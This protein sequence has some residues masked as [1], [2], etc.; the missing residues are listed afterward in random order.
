MGNLVDTP[1][2]R[3]VHE[4][5]YIRIVPAEP[6]YI[7][8]PYYDPEI[9]Y[10]ERPYAEPYLT[11]SAPWLVGSWLTYDFDWHRHR[12]YCGDWHGDWDY[13]HRRDRDYRGEPLYINNSFTNYRVWEGDSRR[14][15][16]STGR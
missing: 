12:L 2:Q 13:H 16:G 4:E 14:R 8:V 15:L 9:V 1:Q 10:Y 6:E 3:V 7:Y 5:S 11:F